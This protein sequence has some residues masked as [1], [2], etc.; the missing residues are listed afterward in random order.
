MAEPSWSDVLLALH[1]DGANGSTTFTES[2]GRA[3]SVSGA[4]ISTAQSKFGGSS[5]SFSPANFTSLYARNSDFVL[6]AGDFTVEGFV[7]L[8]ASQG[9]YA[10]LLGTG[11]IFSGYQIYVNHPSAPGKV[12]AAMQSRSNASTR[13]ISTTSV[14]DN[15]WHHVAVSRE[16]GVLRVFVDGVLEASATV[17]HSITS[18]ALQVGFDPDNSTYL[19][20]YVDDLRVSRTAVYTAAFTPRTAP[21]DSPA[22]TADSSWANVALLMHMN[23][24]AGSSTFIDEKGKAVTPLNGTVIGSPGKFGGGASEFAGVD[25][26]YLS[27]AWSTDFVFGSGVFCIEFWINTTDTDTTVLDFYDG[28]TGSWEVCLSAG[29]VYLSNGALIGP[30]TTAV[31]DGQWHHVA[32]DRYAGQITY[33]VDTAWAGVVSNSTNFNATG[34]DALYVG[35]YVNLADTTYDFTGSIDELRITKGKARYFGQELF[36]IQSVEYGNSDGAA[37]AYTGTLDGAMPYLAGVFDGAYS[38]PITGVADGGVSLAGSVAAATLLPSSI[39]NTAVGKLQLF[40]NFLGTDLYA[41][42]LVGALYLAGE[43]VG[44]VG[45]NAAALGTMVVSGTA[46]GATRTPGFA[47]GKIAFGGVASCAVGNVGVLGGQYS[48]AKKPHHCWACS[49]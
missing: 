3:L 7:K 18:D 30:G 11:G 31:N 17:T 28:T 42:D 27:V 48:L 46:I 14:L 12:L 25:S 26:N 49:A 47:G 41:A 1:M 19:S 38:D 43:S 45:N 15:A 34:Q 10:T 36:Q 33:Y 2:T 32:I 29:K 5:G 16:S 6:G 40:G 23:G 9:S 39:A 37:P 21:F 8:A 20:G 44:A 35:G 22:Q 4:T 13:V 24:T